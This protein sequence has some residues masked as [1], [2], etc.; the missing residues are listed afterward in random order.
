M[1]FDDDVVK[2]A[3]IFQLSQHKPRQSNRGEQQQTTD[4]G[5]APH[6]AELA[7]PEQPYEDDHA[8]QDQ[9]NQAF[10]QH[11]QPARGKPRARPARMYSDCAVGAYEG[12]GKAAYGGTD[13]GGDEDVVI[14]E[15][16]S[17]KKGQATSHHQQGSA[18][19]GFPC[20]FSGR[21]INANEHQASV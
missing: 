13:P 7:S 3:R 2:K 19:G 18:C 5:K 1:L 16:T 8:G 4:P 9:T 12:E 21:Q 14:D 17:K 11:R 15:L 20:D 6:F 10:A